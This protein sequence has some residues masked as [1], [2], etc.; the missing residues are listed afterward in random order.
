LV[1]GCLANFESLETFQNA[2]QPAAVGV[3]YML[4]DKNGKWVE[5]LEVTEELWIK[6]MQE[7]LNGILMIL[8]SVEKLLKTGGN[9]AISAGLYMF[10]V[11]EYGKLLLLKN[12]KPSKEIIQIKYKNEFRNHRAKFG[13]A[14]KTLPKECIILHEGAFDREAF[15]PEAFD[16]DEIADCETRQAVFYSDFISSG[17]F[18]K[19]NPSVDKELLE[20]AVAQLKTIVL[21][22]TIP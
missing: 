3:S 2:G 4:K 6:M 18:I 5:T 14:I 21:V 20:K 16:T 13:I 11:E 9:S 10:A 8:D 15:D 22:T 1:A 17:D 7:T 19:P 12:Y